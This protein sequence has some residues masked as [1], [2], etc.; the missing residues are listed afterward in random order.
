MAASG[1]RDER[2]AEG[3]TADG[4][5]GAARSCGSCM[6]VGLASSRSGRCSRSSGSS[7]TSIKTNK[8]LY[9]QA[10]ILPQHVHR[11]ALQRGHPQDA[12]SSPTSRTACWSPRCTTMIAMVDRRA[13]GLRDHAASTSGGG[14]SWRA[15]RSSPTWCRA[16]C[17]SSRST[18][19]RY[20]LHLTNKALGL[21]VIYLIFTVPFCTWLAISYFNTIPYELEEAA[22]VDGATRLQV[23]RADHPAAGAAGAGGDRALRLHATRGTSSSSP[24]C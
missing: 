18:R 2:A 24:C 8:D 12:A 20:Q 4:L 6:V 11:R 23:A 10:S 3:R 17:S 15:R 7:T 19:S 14:H 13:G 1:T 21:V 22:L 16:R 9:Q 5:V